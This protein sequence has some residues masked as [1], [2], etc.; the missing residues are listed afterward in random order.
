MN[1]NTVRDIIWD[2]DP[3]GIGDARDDVPNEYDG[4]A[5]L[6]LAMLGQGD[7]PARIADR[8][9]RELR[10]RWG[11]VPDARELELKIASVHADGDVTQPDRPVQ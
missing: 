4:L 1:L 3:A 5:S 11:V 6:T 7:E 9:A 8:I 2:W 10:E